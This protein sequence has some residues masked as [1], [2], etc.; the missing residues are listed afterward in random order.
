[1]KYRKEID[2]LRAIAVLSVILFHAKFEF[3]RGG[4]VGVDIFFVISGYLITSIIIDEM[5]K[6]SFSLINF[7]ERRARRILPPLFFMMLCML[8]I[9][10]LW[11]TPQDLEDFSKNLMGV[12]L[13]MSN[14]LFYLERGYFDT[15]SELN[16]LLHTWSLAVEEQYYILFPLFFMV[17]YKAG[18][19]WILFFLSMLAFISVFLAQ[20][21]SNTHPTFTFYLLP[22][23]AFEILIGSLT[24]FYMHH[25]KKSYSNAYVGFVGFML[26]LYSIFMFDKHTP[27]PSL[28][29]LIPTIGTALILV[30]SNNNNSV[31]KLLGIHPLVGIGLISYSAYLWHQ[32]MFAF[33][34]MRGVDEENSVLLGWIVILSIFL[35]YLSWRYIEKP[36]RN[37]NTI[38]RKRVFI[39]GFM[40]SLFFMLMGLLGYMNEG[41]ES[42]LTGQDKA[43]AESMKYDYPQSFRMYRCFM[44]EENTYLDFK[45]ECFGEHTSEAYLIWGDSHAAA[46]YQGLRSV[47][48]DVIQLTASLCAPC[49]ETI[50]SERP[51]C[52]EI[53]E[54]VKNKIKELKP[55]K[56]FLQSSWGMYEKENVIGFLYKTIDFIKRESPQTK[57]AIIGSV[58]LWK[59]SLPL[60]LMRKKL[61]LDQVRYLDLSSYEELVKIDSKLIDLAKEKEIQYIS[62]LDQ[63]CV[64]GKC[65]AVTQ[66]KGTFFPT[67][68]DGGHLTEAGSVYLFTQLKDII[69][70]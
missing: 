65:L 37:I 46:S 5:D 58:P 32:P 44:G 29:T 43:I 40:G 39:C 38:N 23:R 57:I 35:G 45:K 61:G 59:P 60:I 49:V 14:V 8:P 31:G 16:P 19:K 21:G 1:M 7:Y 15:A 52:L 28:Y 6:G 70:N 18:K 56:I 11:M 17:G 63:L 41:F 9:S 67:T 54:F 13:F 26:V 42:R 24:S 30:F 50:F 53:N 20:W 62:V 12:T 33:L 34:N 68:V 25:K 69:N 48:R 4:F 64:N 10:W 47:H 51:H 36:F 2:G 22:T 27:Y 66:Y 55:K 3:F